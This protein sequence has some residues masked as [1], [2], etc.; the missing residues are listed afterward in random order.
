M[1]SDWGEPEEVDPPDP[2]EYADY[3]EDDGYPFRTEKR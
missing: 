3:E 1:R 2:V